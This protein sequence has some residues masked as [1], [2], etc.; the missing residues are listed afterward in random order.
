MHSKGNVLGTS[1]S[2]C[3]SLFVEHHDFILLFIYFLPH[4]LRNPR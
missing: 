4:C 2:L 1:Y 3:F